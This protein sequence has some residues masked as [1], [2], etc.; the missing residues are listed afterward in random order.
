VVYSIQYYDVVLV[1][2]LASLLAGLAVGWL[3]ALPVT[4][5]VPLFAVIGALII[6]HGLFVNGPVERPGD[7]RERVEAFE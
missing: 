4:A 3:T 5:T 1:G 7:L 6:G 2:V